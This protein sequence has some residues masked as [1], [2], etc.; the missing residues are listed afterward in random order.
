MR[1]FSF[2]LCSRVLASG[3]KLEGTFDKSTNHLI[4]GVASMPDGRVFKGSFDRLTG[5]PLA[6]AQLEEDGD[7]YRGAF[8]D[9]WQRDG[10]GEAFLLD[11][12]HYKGTFKDDELVS[13]VVRIPDGSNEVVFEGTLK[14]EEFLNGTVSQHDFTYSGAFAN[15]MPHGKGVLSFASGATQEG[16]FFNGKLHGHN[17][18]LK[19]ESG[20]LYVGE[21]NMGVCTKGQLFTPTYHYDGEFNAEGRAN[22]EGTQTFLAASPKLIFTGLWQ[23]GSLM[24]GTCV[25]EDGAP[26]D[27]V[28]N[29]E[30]RQEVMGSRAAH[31]EQAGRTLLNDIEVR[32][33]EMM[34]N[35]PQSHGSGPTGVGLPGSGGILDASRAIHDSET[36]KSSLGTL[37][38]S[39]GEVNSNLAKSKLSEGVGCQKIVEAHMDEQ[40]RR[41]QNG[42]E[43]EFAPNAAWSSIERSQ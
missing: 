43:D 27:W 32:A 41:F 4:D 28:D 3:L 26:V 31:S 16:T 35:D 39:G 20:F 33:M 7:L 19:L 34:E 24:R 38:L 18:R 13:G 36:F 42:G 15:N 17:C 37:D 10:L 6:G 30:L 1:R 14:D 11:G 29:H 23:D 22:G 5:R 25:D 12:T 2:L 9:R 8:N 21:F 40:L